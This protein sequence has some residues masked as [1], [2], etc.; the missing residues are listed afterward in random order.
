MSGSSSKKDAP[1]SKRPFNSGAMDRFLAAAH[2]KLSS[3]AE[4]IDQLFYSY[5]ITPPWVIQP[6]GIDTLCSD[7]GIHHTDVRILMLAWKMQ[8][9][10][11]GYF[12]LDEWRRALTALRA[13][14]IIKLKAALP[15]L[16][17]E[18]RRSSNRANFY[19]YAFKYNLTEEKQKFIDTETVC[20]LLNLVLRS[21]FLPQVDA[22]IHYLKIQTDYRVINMDQWMGFYRFCNEINFPE[23]DNYDS[24]QA[25]PLIVDD[26][27]DWIRSHRG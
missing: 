20:A 13:D 23:L 14:T 24:D 5:A 19:S 6:Q 8:A 2:K 3:E 18:V 7:L 22:L 17:R 12:T 16:E 1:N 15:E 26:F 9:E 25:W 21:E 4:R 27:V 10:K 11:Q